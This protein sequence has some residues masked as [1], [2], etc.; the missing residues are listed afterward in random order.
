MVWLKRFGENG[1]AERAGEG[2]PPGQWGNWAPLR[3]GWCPGLPVAP[4]RHDIT[5]D[6]PVG[7]AT[8][9]T[10]EAAF[11]GGPPPG[12]SISLSTYVVFY[13]PG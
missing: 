2:V 4:I 6:L 5:A 8:E 1:C 3:A 7:E 10:Y 11:A 12:G 9:I 13:G